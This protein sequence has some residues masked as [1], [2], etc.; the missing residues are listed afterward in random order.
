MTAPPRGPS[1]EPA[2]LARGLTKRFGAVRAVDGIDFEVGRGRVVA[3][4]GGNG[5][6]KTTTLAMLMGLVRPSAGTVRALG[7]DMAEDR[8]RALPRMNF[9]SP[10]VELPR[11]LTVE[12]NLKVFARLY[13]VADARARIA[14][15]AEELD[16]ARFLKR[17]TGSLSAGEKTR[18]SLAKALLN[19]PALLLLDEP[20]ASLDPD[21]ADWVRAYLDRYRRESGAAILMASHNM[22]E[23]ERLCD[24]VLIM[25]AGQIVDRGTPQALVDRFGRE[26]L[27]EVYLDIARRR[28]RG[29]E[30]A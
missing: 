11:A 6:G 21:A 9:S 25:R 8:F 5:A 1:S 23:V 14:R 30:A 28:G 26:T 17:A 29:A 3:L 15:L 12:E 2:I 22:A 10:Y 4:L 19:A 18:V 27:E 7:V 13:G 16:A 24:D 20:T